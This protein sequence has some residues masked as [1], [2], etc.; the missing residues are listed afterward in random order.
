MAKAAFM[1]VDLWTDIV[2]PWCYIGVTRFE[3][4]LERFHD[5]V[6]VRLHAFQLDPEAPVPGIP[7]LQRYA[8]KLGAEAPSILERVTGEA[9]KDGIEMRFDRHFV[10]EGAQL[11]AI[12]YGGH[13]GHAHL[14]GPIMT[15]S[16][17]ANNGFCIGSR[18][19]L[20]LTFT[21]EI[22]AAAALGTAWPRH[23]RARL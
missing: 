10:S 20:T 8:Q 11:G 16:V 5:D 2:C 12:A 4:A 3:R 19:R 22:G 23:E 18:L 15:Y 7:A 9:E 6:E 14:D 21:E 13:K 1:V 17:E